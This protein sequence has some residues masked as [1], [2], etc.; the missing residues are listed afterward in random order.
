MQG[1]ADPLHPSFGLVFAGMLVFVVI[2]VALVCVV[3]QIGLV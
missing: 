1:F 2:W 3:V